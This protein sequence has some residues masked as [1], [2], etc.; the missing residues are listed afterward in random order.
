MRITQKNPVRAAITGLDTYYSS[1]GSAAKAA[2]DVM[3]AHGI[4]VD[5]PSLEGDE[6]HVT[7]PL[8]Q[9]IPG[10]AVCA[11][12]DARMA[13]DEYENVL[14]FAWYTLCS[15]RVELTTYVS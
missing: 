2:Y 5:F 8:R 10:S 1:K 3:E 4:S 12:C 14:V 15:G 11:V 9:S 13:D 6:G 7:C